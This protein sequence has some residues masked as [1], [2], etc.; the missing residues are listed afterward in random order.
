MLQFVRHASSRARK[1]APAAAKNAAKQRVVKKPKPQKAKKPAAA[2]A[3][4]AADGMSIDASESNRSRYLSHWRTLMELEHQAENSAVTER[5]QEWPL[6]RLEREGLTLTGLTDARRAGGLFSREAVRFQAP[7][8]SLRQHSFDVGDEAY[9]SHNGPLDAAGN[10]H[11]NVIRCEIAEINPNSL[12]VA[13][14]PSASASLLENKV[15]FGTG[16]GGETGQ[17]RP[18]RLDRMANSTAYRRTVAAL[19]EWTS[20]GFDFGAST[21]LRRTII[22]GATSAVREFPSAS[23]GATPSWRSTIGAE[24]KAAASDTHVKLNNPQRTAVLGAL[25][26]FSSGG[27]GAHTIS[28]IQGPPGTG[29]STAAV[30]LL[31]LAAMGAPG[32]LLAT[33]DSNAAVDQILEALLAQGVVATRVGRPSRAVPELVNASVEAKCAAHPEMK[34]LDEQRESLRQLRVVAS[35]LVGVARTE[36]EKVIRD[37]WRSVRTIEGRLLREVLEQSEVVCATL[38]GCGSHAM[39][40]MRFPLVVVDECTQATEP[41][42]ALALTRAMSDLVLIGDQMQLSPTC[43]SKEAADSGLGRSLFE[44]MVQIADKVP[45]HIHHSMLTIQ[46][47]MHPQLRLF[48]SE[49]F[50]ERSPQLSLEL[51]IR[52][53]SAAVTPLGS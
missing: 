36:V 49:T 38:A 23:S 45:K 30:A 48:P 21:A 50:C 33:A 10:L 53:S 2:A 35:E 40:P 22:E 37:G 7:S 31:K 41:R 43:L 8:L 52:A 11:R 16:G 47:R 51:S 18:W 13:L 26:A 12:T 39:L 14:E 24:A 9:I 17:S 3:R 1:A 5:L 32:P 27:S 28:L 19:E 4:M 46:Y 20:S 15:N 25:D 6:E 42:T 29:K 44:R 34:E